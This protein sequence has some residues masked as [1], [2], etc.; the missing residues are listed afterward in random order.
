[1]SDIEV[2]EKEIKDER[3]AYERDR[4]L[5][6]DES[7][8]ALIKQRKEADLWSGQKMGKEGD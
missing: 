5:L 6:T 7:L 4:I 3:Q 2:T 8:V 1:M